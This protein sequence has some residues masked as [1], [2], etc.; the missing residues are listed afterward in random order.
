VHPPVHDRLTRRRPTTINIRHEGTTTMTTTTTTT[1]SHLSSVAAM[2][3]D[4]S[5]APDIIVPVADTAQRVD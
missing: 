2:C 1:T 5:S 4:P 3:R